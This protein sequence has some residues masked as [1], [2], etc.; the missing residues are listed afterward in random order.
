MRRLSYTSAAD[1]SQWSY[2][3]K[4]PLH[5]DFEQV[6]NLDA[7]CQRVDHEGF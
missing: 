3:N 2:C 5:V 6:V 7:L 1:G 4:K